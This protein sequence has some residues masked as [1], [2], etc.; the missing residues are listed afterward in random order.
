MRCY[1]FAYLF[2]E[3]LLSLGPGGEDDPGYS[4]LYPTYAIADRKLS[5]VAGKT[6]YQILTCPNCFC[7]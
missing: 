6:T 5:D 4:D 1:Y 7:A 3:R 2:K